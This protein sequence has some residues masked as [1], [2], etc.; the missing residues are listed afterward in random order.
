MFDLL[1]HLP[2]SNDTHL[3]PWTPSRSAPAAPPRVGA[4]Q[5]QPTRQRI[6]QHQH[7]NTH[8]LVAIPFT[9]SR[10]N[11]ISH[12]PP[13]LNQLKRVIATMMI[14]IT[15]TTNPGKSP[16]L[17]C[18]KPR[19]VLIEDLHIHTQSLALPKIVSSHLPCTFTSMTT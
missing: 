7:M 4:T 10:T 8:Y 14:H 1:P 16:L 18:I 17:I 13:S 6:R 15:S 11:F 5:A 3:S 12:S 9:T 2:L 19:G